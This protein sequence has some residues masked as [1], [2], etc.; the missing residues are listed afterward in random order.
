MD[1][2]ASAALDYADRNPSEAGK[3]ALMAAAAAATA[4]GRDDL[5]QALVDRGR[6]LVEDLIDIELHEEG[7]GHVSEM[8]HL[9]QQG[10][11]LAVSDAQQ[12]QLRRRIDEALNGCDVWVGWIHYTHRLGATMPEDEDLAFAE[13]NRGWTE[14]HVVQ[15]SRDDQGRFHGESTADVKFPNVVYRDDTDDVPECGDDFVDLEAEGRPGTGRVR[16]L[17]EGVV[18]DGVW[19]VTKVSS[20][21][22]ANLALRTRYHANKWQY[23]E[24]TCVLAVNV[25][26]WLTWTDSYTTQLDQGFLGP[27]P[28]SLAEMLSDGHQSPNP[29]GRGAPCIHG[30]ESATVEAQPGVW[31]FT[32][33]YGR[34]TSSR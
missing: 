23:T 10:I 1:D 21:P 24:G 33:V 7:C 25:D 30:F 26:E 4:A 27:T 16:V 6:T 18:A 31:P 22:L 13:G 11:A 29:L 2:L 17:F 14:R 5:V 8:M 9:L 12:E 32:D 28:P 20:E 34:G 3:S 19:T 15:L